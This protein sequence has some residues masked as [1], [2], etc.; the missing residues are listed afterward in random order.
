MSKSNFFVDRLQKLV[1][2]SEIV[3]W[4]SR[5]FLGDRLPKFAIISVFICKFLNFF[6]RSVLEIGEFLGDYLPKFV[7][8]SQIFSRNSRFSFRDCLSKF[9]I[10]FQ[11]H[12]TYLWIYFATRGFISKSSHETRNYC[13]YTT[14]FAIFFP[15][16]WQK[17]FHVFCETYWRSL[18][19]IFQND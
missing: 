10:F 2:L 16:N 11:D 1:I 8:F 7:I 4:N 13:I 5:F 12:L 19:F 6:K 9:A 3:C 17:K 15:H 18:R 14:K